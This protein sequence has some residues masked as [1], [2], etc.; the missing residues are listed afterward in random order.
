[1]SLKS[2]NKKHREAIFDAVSP[3]CGTHIVYRCMYSFSF[4]PPLPFIHPN[5]NFLLRTHEGRALIKKYKHQYLILLCRSVVYL[6]ECT[7]FEDK[8]HKVSYLYRNSKVVWIVFKFYSGPLWFP[9][10]KF[11]IWWCW[12]TKEKLYIHL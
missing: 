4:I 11:R 1:M 8:I 9:I 2:D 10:R 3:F 6:T 7:Y 12:G 5:Q